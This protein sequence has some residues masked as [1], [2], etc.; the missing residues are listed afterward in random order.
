[1]IRKT[2]NG[3]VVYSEGGRRLSR[4][5]TSRRAAERRLRQIEYFKHQHK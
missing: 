4:P 2:S 3:Y 5:L 1:M